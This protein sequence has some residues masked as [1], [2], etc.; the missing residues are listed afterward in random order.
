MTSEPAAAD[1]GVEVLPDVSDDGVSEFA[2]AVEEL[3]KDKLEKPK[4]LSESLWMCHQRGRVKC[5]GQVQEV[6]CVYTT[7]TYGQYM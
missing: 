7:G 6:I 1:G 3:I 5:R 4:R 2:T